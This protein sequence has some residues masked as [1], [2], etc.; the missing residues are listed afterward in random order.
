MFVA[1]SFTISVFVWSV[2]YLFLFLFIDSILMVLNLFRR[3]IGCATVR[4]ICWCSFMSFEV[5]FRR[6]SFLVVV[7]VVVDVN[8]FAA[9]FLLWTGCSGT[10]YRIF[11]FWTKK[12][13]HV[14]IML[15][16]LNILVS[17]LLLLGERKR[18]LA[19]STWHTARLATVP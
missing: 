3:N 2:F 6:I 8:V 9:D 15:F 5:S 16:P 4:S 12:S 7:D 14:R 17:F 1:L 19:Q 13:V 18:C 11:F 10:H